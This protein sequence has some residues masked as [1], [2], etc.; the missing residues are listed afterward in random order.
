MS[1]TAASL[2]ST[3]VATVMMMMMLMVV[4]RSISPVVMSSASSSSTT[5][6]AASPSATSAT[7]PGRI[8][9]L[10]IMLTAIAIHRLVLFPRTP[11][12]GGVGV[13]EARARLAGIEAIAV[14]PDAAAVRGGIL[15][16]LEQVI[17]NV[18]RIIVAVDLV[19]GDAD[20][21]RQSVVVALYRSRLAAVAP[22][23]GASL[24][25]GQHA[26]VYPDHVITGTCW[27]DRGVGHHLQALTIERIVHC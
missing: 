9:K 8:G 24:Q 7:T 18:R 13:D 1:T 25:L 5:S 19:A 20:A 6:T 12:G 27:I 22:R 3:A 4:V 15:G 11:V 21:Q 26:V 2:T 17:W 16:V 10:R 14:I 23:T